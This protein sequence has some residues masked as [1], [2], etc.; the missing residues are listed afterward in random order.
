VLQKIKTRCEEIFTASVWFFSSGIWIELMAQIFQNPNPRPEIEI[1]MAGRSKGLVDTSY[2][3]ERS[4]IKAG[5]NV[6]FCQDGKR[7]QMSWFGL[8]EG[9][10]RLFFHRVQSAQTREHSS[11]GC[12]LTPTRAGVEARKGVV[13]NDKADGARYPVRWGLSLLSLPTATEEHG[14]PPKPHDFTEWLSHLRCPASTG[15]RTALPPW[16]SAPR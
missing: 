6:I 5:M 1:I 10:S 12:N 7:E 15:V 16:C 13:I 8:V 4:Q 3:L 11:K 9:P 14:R 2:G